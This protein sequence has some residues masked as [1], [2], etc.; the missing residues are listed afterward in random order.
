MFAHY[1]QPQSRR[2]RTR[3]FGL[4]VAV[5]VSLAL[6]PCAVAAVSESDCPHCPSEIEAIYAVAVQEVERRLVALEHPERS[7]LRGPVEAG[8]P[9]RLAPQSLLAVLGLLV[10]ALGDRGLE[11]GQPVHSPRLPQ[12]AREGTIYR[13]TYCALRSAT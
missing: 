3:V 11:W 12:V 7:R 1:T 2:A 13:R 8:L 4:F 6:Q 10:I 5:W 9:R